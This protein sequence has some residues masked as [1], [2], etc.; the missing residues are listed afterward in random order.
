MVTYAELLIFA[1]YIGMAGYIMWLQHRVAEATKAGA[2]MAMVLN[3]LAR[4]ELEIERHNDG[5]KIIR[6]ETTDEVST[7]QRGV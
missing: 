2:V 4:G 5:F 3:D 6:R 7:H 1:V